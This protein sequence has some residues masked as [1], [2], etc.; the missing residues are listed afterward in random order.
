M[1]QY[2]EVLQRLEHRK[3]GMY[4]EIEEYEHPYG[5]IRILSPQPLV[6]I[7]AFLEYWLQV[8]G[9]VPATDY[10]AV[11]ETKQT[12][13]IEQTREIQKRYLDEIEGY[14]SEEDFE[15]LR[16]IS[17]KI[18]CFA[19]ILVEIMHRIEKDYNAK[20]ELSVSRD[21]EIGDRVFVLVGGLKF[22]SL[23]EKYE[24][25]DELE[26]VVWS[27]IEKYK[28]EYD[29]SEVEEVNILI[30]ILVLE[31]EYDRAEGI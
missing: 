18:E 24:L 17:T 1:N 29:P 23:E 7:Q 4:S 25:E 5:F 12:P 11:I 19:P 13:E 14:A 10:I 2:D 3:F 20:V 15:F 21:S 9:R 27:V 8:S 30:S 31:E 26:R 6:D 28:E 16:E 22:E